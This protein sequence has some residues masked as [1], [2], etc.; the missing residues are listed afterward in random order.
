[1]PKSVVGSLVVNLRAKTAVFSKEMKKARGSM[2]KLKASATLLKGSFLALSGAGVKYAFSKLT[3]FIS[4]IVRRLKIMVKV[5]AAAFV[6]VTVAITKMAA[7]AVEHENLFSVTMGKYT[8]STRQWSE[9]MSNALGVSAFEIRKYSGPLF[10]MI[11]NMGVAEKSALEMSKD[12]TTLAFDM[13]SFRELSFEESFNKIRSG[14]VG[15]P[16]PLQDL[17]IVINE[18][19]VKSH[20]LANGWLKQGEALSNTA[21]VIMRYRLLMD[22]AKEDQGDLVRTSGSLV[23]QWRRLSSNVADLGRAIGSM[24]L[25]QINQYVTAINQWLKAGGGDKIKKWAAVVYRHVFSLVN[26]LIAAFKYV[27]SDWSKTWDRM[28]EVTVV[29][30]KNIIAIIKPMVLK[31]G[32][33]IGQAIREGFVPTVKGMTRSAMGVKPE[34]VGDRLLDSKFSPV[35]KNKDVETISFK[36]GMA[37]LRKISE[38]TS[39][40]MVTER[41]GL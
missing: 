21:K 1:M 26:K 11:K 5:A 22:L 9:S 10:M 4:G 37:L 8:E 7:S 13:A 24:L 35:Y 30:I 18:T 19:A 36:E 15:M 31:L 32:R 2:A 17:G 20:A 29:A 16:R 41:E 38:N 25:P 33:E 28:K 12:L 39:P 27:F 23:N 3:G 14:I 6:G 34:S 40:Q